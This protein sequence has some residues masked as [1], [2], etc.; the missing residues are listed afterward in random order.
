MPKKNNYLPDPKANPETY[1]LVRSKYGWFYRR[2]RG[3]KT[4]AALNATLQANKE[5]Q[6]VLVACASRF[7]RLL[8]ACGAGFKEGGLWSK[9]NELFWKSPTNEF[10]DFIRQTE[11]LE[12]HKKYP[13]TRFNAACTLHLAFGEST[14][15]ATLTPYAAPSSK[16]PNPQFCYT[17]ALLFYTTSGEPVTFVRQETLWLTAADVEPVRFVLLRPEAASFYV[18]VLTLQMGKDGKATTGL[19]G[20]GMRV[21]Q[22]GSL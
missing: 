19:A 9:V 15:T 22:T 21:V 4:K 10:A 2:K 11:G 1:I 5:R 18:A 8:A 14:V 20:M 3:T 6:A 16:G 12:L 7:Y 13:L 17:V